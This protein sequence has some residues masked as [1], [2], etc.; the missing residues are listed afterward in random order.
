MSTRLELAGT[1]AVSRFR[2]LFLVAALYDAI[3]GAAFFLLYQPIYRML[4][5]E[6]PANPAYL[7]LSAGFVFVQ[8]IGYWFVFRN[9]M[10]NT[11]LVLVG[12]IYKVIY[13]GVVF[14]YMLI[15]QLPHATFAWFAVCDILFIV[16]F[17]RF[18]VLARPAAGEPQPQH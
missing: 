2:T 10:R 4:G 15:G 17:L 11:D 18:L 14:Y 1:G 6:L 16:G 9:M 8:G 5:A 12:V 7:H 13:T 3:L